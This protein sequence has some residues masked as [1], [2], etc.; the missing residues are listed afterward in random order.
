[1]AKQICTSTRSVSVYQRSHQD[2][3][4]EH[5]QTF[6]FCA[7]RG[8]PQ[9]T[10]HSSCLLLMP[11]RTTSKLEITRTKNWKP[12]L[13]IAMSMAR[14][15]W[16]S[17][18]KVGNSRLPMVALPLIYSMYTL[19]TWNHACYAC[20][21]SLAHA[22]VR[23]TW[24]KLTL[25]AVI[26]FHSRI[27]V[28]SWHLL[29][30][31]SCARRMARLFK[32]RLGER[33]HMTSFCHRFICLSFA[34]CL[35]RQQAADEQPIY[36]EW[37]SFWRVDWLEMKIHAMNAAREAESMDTIG[38]LHIKIRTILTILYVQCF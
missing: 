3:A 27:W 23:N 36:G 1:M 11:K 22:Q 38:L 8:F 33:Y 26:V 18:L 16:C 31:C 25:L 12:K 30:T 32:L 37:M 14:R 2:S 15:I 4:S 28:F 10:S 35:Y 5:K 34:D 21:C 13:E 17:A 19:Y 9:N 20:A 6:D 24:Y 29:R 7:L